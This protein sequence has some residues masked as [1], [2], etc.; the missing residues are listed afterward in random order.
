MRPDYDYNAHA[1]TPGMTDYTNV[2][3]DQVAKLESILRLLTDKLHPIMLPEMIDESDDPGKTMPTVSP[4][5][6]DVIRATER[7]KDLQFRIGKLVD[8]VDL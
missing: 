1:E 3:L 8:R 4:V 7:I 2:L 6:Q 5:Q